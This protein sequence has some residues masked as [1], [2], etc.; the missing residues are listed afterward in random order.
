M[1]S[2]PRY[3]HEI[4]AWEYDQ[5]QPLP[6][7]GEIEWYLKYASKKNPILELAC[8][9][10]RITIPI[11]QAGYSIHAVDCSQTM[12]NR[13]QKKLMG[14]DISTRNR[15][16]PVCADMTTF[17]PAKPY[18]LV[19]L[20]YNSI[21]YMETK[22]NIN[23]FFKHVSTKLIMNGCFLFVVRRWRTEDFNEGK[24]TI[25][26]MDR[27]LIVPETKVTV[28]TKLTLTLD[29]DKQ[30]VVNEREYLITYPDGKTQ[31][32]KQVSRSPVIRTNQYVN[33]LENVG[34]E[35]QVFSDYDETPDDGKSREICFVC[36]KK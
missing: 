25:N 35:M 22:E 30:Y 20:A 26:W 17:S 24:R 12:L 10:G 15:I 33:M 8:G 1:S 16:F 28:G 23:R 11:A 13:L 6:F 3:D 36:R 27:P 32:I 2:F 4:L 34:F 21:Q 9:S 14:C 31:Y 7:L 5:R 18:S 19:L 29:G